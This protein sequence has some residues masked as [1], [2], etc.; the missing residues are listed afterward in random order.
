LASF[1]TARE[2]PRVAF[3]SLVERGLVTAGTVLTDDKRRYVATVRPDGSLMS[4]PQ[5]GS[6]HKIGALV[7]GAQACNGWT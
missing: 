1:T 5:V 4:G 2:A 7:Q 3:S 6:I